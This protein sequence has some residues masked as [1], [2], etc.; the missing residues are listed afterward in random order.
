MKRIFYD[1]SDLSSCQSLANRIWPQVFKLIGYKVMKGFWVIIVVIATLM[2]NESV[3]CQ[4]YPILDAMAH[5]FLAKQNHIF[6]PQNLDNNDTD[7]R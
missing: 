4:C 7:E 1:V 6:Q 5:L 2:L 3:A